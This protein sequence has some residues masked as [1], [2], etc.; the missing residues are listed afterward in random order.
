MLTFHLDSVNVSMVPVSGKAGIHPDSRAHS[1]VREWPMMSRTQGSDPGWQNIKDVLGIWQLNILAHKLGWSVQDMR[2]QML[3]AVG[4]A[5]KHGFD[6]GCC[7]VPR[8]TI[9]V[10]SSVTCCHEAALNPSRIQ[11][12]SLWVVPESPQMPK[13]PDAQVPVWNYTVFS[14]QLHTSSHVL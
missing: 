1:Q 10:D 3:L 6:L 13:P 8:D 14:G 5:P 9:H 11:G 2:N 7:T 4:S 12:V